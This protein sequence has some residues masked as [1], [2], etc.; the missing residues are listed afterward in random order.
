MHGYYL[1]NT[2]GVLY[3]ETL[4]D[5]ITITASQFAVP[6]QEVAGA[7]TI[8]T[9]QQIE[10]S[11]ATYVAELLQQ[12]PG[13]NVSRQGGDGGLTQI[14]LRGAEANQVLVLIDGIEVNDPASSS[15]FN[16]THLRAANIERIEVMRGPQSS[17]WGSDA[18][19]GVINI[20]TTSRLLNNN[21]RLKNSYGSE[22]NYAGDASLYGRQSRF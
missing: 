3:A 13:L 10:N 1:C 17:L 2:A 21:V 19:A 6:V 16:F 14:R 7:V 18:L 4:I 12:V 20:V 5:P 15:E 22:S 8:I 11:Q 9:K